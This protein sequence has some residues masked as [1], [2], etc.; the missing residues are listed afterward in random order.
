MQAA[1]WRL[2]LT[3]PL[4]ANG[5][6]SMT[7]RVAN[8][9]DLSRREKAGSECL[10]ALLRIRADTRCRAN[11]DFPCSDERDEHRAVKCRCQLGS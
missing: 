7:P 1:A 10:N 11:S 4:C 2:F 3:W 8:G 6:R 9:D 5:G